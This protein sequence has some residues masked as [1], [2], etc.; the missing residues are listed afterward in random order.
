MN[1][2]KGCF[3][4]AVLLMAVGTDVR[5]DATPQSNIDVTALVDPI[6][7]TEGVG[8]AGV[9]FD[10]TDFWL[11]RWASAR[12]TRIS[13]SGAYVDSFDIPG[14]TGTR[15]MTWDGTHFWIA[16]NTTTLSRVDPVSKTVVA[17]IT[18]PITTRYATFDPTADAGAGGFWIGNFSTDIVLVG[19]TGATL[20]TIPAA[21]IGSTGRYGI[22]FDNVTEPTPILWVF[23][24]GGTNNVDIIIVDLP[25]GTPRAPALNLFPSLPGTTTSALAGGIFLANGLPAGSKTLLAMVQGTPNNILATL[26]TSGPSAPGIFLDGFE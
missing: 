8:Y 2:L 15:A 7:P 16:N 6:F 4:A 9:G 5:A 26:S 3:A 1:V 10:G 24:Q 20:S 17:T 23:N 14:L 22:A 11:S 21:T 12:I 19:M 18:L 25:S 13:T